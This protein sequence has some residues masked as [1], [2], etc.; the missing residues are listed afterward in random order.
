MNADVDVLIAGAGPTGLLL[1]NELGL[2]GVRTA[3]AE[4][5]PRRTG[6]SKALN[7][8]PRTAEV[9]D[10]RGWLEPLLDRSLA[11][12]PSGHFAGLPLNYGALDTAFPHQVGIPQA[13]VEEFLEDHLAEHGVPV[14]RGR[15]LTSFQQDA[16]GV[17]ATL[18]G[19]DGTESTVQAGYL[20][21]AD[22]GRSTVRRILG[23]PFPGRDGRIGMAVADVELRP[24]DEAPGEPVEGYE[25]HRRVTQVPGG[26]EVFAATE[27][28]SDGT[29][30]PWHLP[31]LSPDPAGLAFLLPLGGG[32]HRLILGG[33]EQQGVDRDAPVTADEVRTALV[34]CP[35]PP[36]ELRAI[37][38]ASRFTDASRQAERYADGR[39]LLAG[40]A[41]HI[42]AP[43]GGQGLNLGM[44]DAF[45]LGW[46]LAAVARGRAPTELLATYH[47][48]RHPVGAR[49][50]ANTRAQMALT[51]PDPDAMAVRDLL[52]DLLTTPEANHHIAA[53]I[54]GTDIRY[55][56][57]GAPHHP[58][59]GARAPGV[60]LPSGRA[61]LLTAAPTSAAAAAAKD[62]GDRV[63]RLGPLG[64]AA[65]G[66]EALLV[67]P[68]GH[69]CWAGRNDDADSLRAA[70]ARWFGPIS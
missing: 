50:L 4:R 12:L 8:Q 48:E 60:Q 33:P 66:D 35:G 5:L 49:V 40:D 46:K 24:A 28:G 32:V 27:A 43:A 26:D 54:A 65:N 22:G 17:T 37:R 67:R 10:C 15:E 29:G 42:H 18:L 59:L 56:M 25:T 63:D 52:A 1:A 20:V 16:D 34:R 19:P 64:P 7:L 38:W 55:P 41:A 61:A 51:L 39:V 23:V 13:R 6:Q 11:L 44:Q 58:L 30:E 70:L 3:V 21:G 53:M 47:T 62:W 2:A 9:L 31:D 45:N 69:V 14:Q 36:R 57:P 68:D